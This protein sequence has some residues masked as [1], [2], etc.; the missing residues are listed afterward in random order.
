MGELTDKAKG[1]GNEAAGKFK[2]VQG[3]VMNDPGKQ[4]EGAAQELKGK[5]QKA[6]GAV[7]GAFGDKV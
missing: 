2:K 1:L 4:A 7:K 3:D 5:A 6:K